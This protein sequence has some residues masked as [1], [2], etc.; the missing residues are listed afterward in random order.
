M[1]RRPAPAPA[2]DGRRRSAAARVSVCRAPPA[3][4]RPRYRPGG[5]GR[6]V[7]GGTEAPD[8]GSVGSFGGAGTFG[9]DG[10]VTQTVTP[11]VPA[12]AVT[13]PPLPDTDTPPPG[14]P[15]SGFEGRVGVLLQVVVG[16]P[17]FF[18]WL[19]GTGVFE[20]GVVGPLDGLAGEGTEAG[21]GAAR[22]ACDVPDAGSATPPATGS[23]G[24]AGAVPQNFTPLAELA[25]SETEPPPPVAEKA[26]LGE[27]GNGVAGDGGL[28]LQNDVGAGDEPSAV[29]RAPAGSTTAD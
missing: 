1:W 22:E 6:P 9:G 25:E 29:V 24:A 4:R 13:P 2:K 18:G 8:P 5:T 16:R 11:P 10:G 28:L 19:V 20:P 21:L 17:P 15:W 3:Y 12:L 26:A 27:P 14:E 23:M 7:G